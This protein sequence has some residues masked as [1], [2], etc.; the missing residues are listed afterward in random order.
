[1]RR[2]LVGSALTLAVA[3]GLAAAAGAAPAGS[4]AAPLLDHPALADAAGKTHRLAEYAGRQGT[5]VVF[6]GTHCPLSNAY[7]PALAELAGRYRARGI[8]FVGVNAVPEEDAAA[9]ERHAR[10]YGLPFPVL[11]DSRAALVTALDARV[12]PEVFLLDRER[13]VRYRGRIDDTYATRTQKRA[14][15]AE[16]DLEA[17][18]EAVLAGKPVARPVTEAL[19]CA[20]VRPGSAARVAAGTPTYHKDVLPILQERCQG[21]HRPGQVA[22][23]HLLTY[24][25]ARGWAKEIKTVTASRQMP[26]WK[27]E[28]G[29]GEFEGE[30]RLS[31]GEL[32]TLAA[33]A[34]GGTPEGD[35]RRAPAPKQ[36]AEGWSLGEP[37]LVLTVPEPYE[38]E[39]AGDDE[40]RVFVLPTGLTEG[41]QVTAIDFRPGNARVVHH[42]VSFVDTT[43]Q[44]RKLDEKDP[45]PGYRSGSGGVRVFGAMIQGVWAP[46]N[47]PRFLPTGVGRPLPKGA[48]LLIQVHYHKTGR[49]ERDQTRVGL[50]FA[51]EPTTRA[52]FTGLLGPL[53]L[54]IPPDAAR[55]EIRASGVFGSDVEVLTIMPHMH[56]LGREMKVGVVLPDGAQRE[57]VWIKEWDYR[58]QDSYRFREPVK[59]P[60]GTRWELTAY[61]DNSSANPLNPSNPPRKVT[62]GEQTTDE[63]AFAILE[64]VVNRPVTA[65]PGSA[66]RAGEAAPAAP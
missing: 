33:W 56:L 1:M 16:R 26:P 8:G 51:R 46:G 52:A 19:G 57:L 11:K 35:A 36:W 48:D 63:M 21:C 6:L 25:D 34:D 31:D 38:V 43:G 24:A 17:A 28:P 9:A 22:P 4:S 12:T 27:A 66:P 45:G 32:R 55:H 60:K 64:L 58:W 23:F 59:L 65:A 62:W 10:E 15:P 30:R 54:E 42:V 37:D 18:L 29:H 7:A 2:A 3:A 39:A 47:F 20:L 14:R 49:K 44:G 61:F 53:R 41:K 13:R 50:Y 40:F 5:V